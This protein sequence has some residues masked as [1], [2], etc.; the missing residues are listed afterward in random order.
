MVSSVN[1]SLYIKR[2][3]EDAWKGYM[4]STLA[5]GAIM[6]GLLYA[7]IPFEKQL[8]K[9]YQNNNVYKDALY[10][11]IK[12]EYSGIPANTIEIVPAQIKFPNTP[13]AIGKNAYYSSKFNQIVLNTEK[14][15]IAGFHELGHAMNNLKSFIP[16]Y[17]QRFRHTGY[18][19][20]GL[21]E[22][23]AIFSRTKPKG[24]KRNFTDFIEDNCGK[25]AFLA[26]L[27]TV[28]EEAIASIKGINIAKKVGIGGSALKSMKALYT[29][30]FMTYLARAS[31][32]GLAVGASRI[33]MD[34]Y[35]RPKKI[36]VNNYFTENS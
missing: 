13:E 35:T 9:E 27:P 36:S 25:I 29:K 7:G 17:L 1:N 15:T 16:K 26:L 32:T 12:P 11:A 18:V 20:A 34:Y 24:E 23:F 3:K 14:T 10:K 2:S 33:I 5:S 4:L 30:A 28:I 21:M 22:Y 8:T 19:I 31:L 6:S